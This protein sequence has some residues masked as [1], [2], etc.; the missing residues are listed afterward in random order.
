MMARALQL[1]P[2]SR[3]SA[4]LLLRLAR[5]KNGR[6]RGNLRSGCDFPPP[7][8][9]LPFRPFLIPAARDPL[10]IGRWSDLRVG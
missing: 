1:F 10:L 6:L 7:T 4:A 3:C 8:L 2:S 9:I 5:I